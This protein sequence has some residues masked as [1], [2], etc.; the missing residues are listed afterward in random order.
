MPAD[1]TAPKKIPLTAKAVYASMAD[2]K[3]AV[4]D[5][6]KDHN[7]SFKWAASK[8]HWAIAVCKKSECDFRI[9]AHVSSK[10]ASEVKVSTFNEDHTCAGAAPPARAS[11][12]NHQ[13][14][15]GLVSY[16]FVCLCPFSPPPFS[17]S[18]NPMRLCTL[19]VLWR[20]SSLLSFRPLSLISRASAP[21]ALHY[22]MSLDWGT[23]E[24]I[25]SLPATLPPTMML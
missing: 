22:R 12:N 21:C 3:L 23:C 19:A 25:T 20:G 6:A 2:F 7:F 10:D 15:V 11:H 4:H 5:Y 24:L 18:S 9:R 8:K 17:S 13:Y 14:L 1:R 16:L